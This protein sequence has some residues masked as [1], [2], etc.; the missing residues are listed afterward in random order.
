MWIQ[1]AKIQKTRR[2]RNFRAAPSCLSGASIYSL[3]LAMV[4]IAGSAPCLISSDGLNTAFGG[5]SL[6][7]QAQDVFVAGAIFVT[8]VVLRFGLLYGVSGEVGSHLHVS[9]A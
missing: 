7:P 5:K 8:V 1:P 9:R 4:A 3:P 6:S 2:P